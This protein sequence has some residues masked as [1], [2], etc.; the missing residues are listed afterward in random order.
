MTNMTKKQLQAA[1]KKVVDNFDVDGS[2]D[3]TRMDMAIQEAVGLRF[4]N[5]S[6]WGLV[7][8]ARASVERISFTLED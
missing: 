3:Y 1:V 8:R 7:D 6:I 5:K 2:T 4:D